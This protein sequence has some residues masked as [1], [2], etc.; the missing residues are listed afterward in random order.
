VGRPGNHYHFVAASPK[1]ATSLRRMIGALHTL[2]ARDVNLLDGAPDRPIWFQFWDTC[3]T[4]PAS[5]FARL[6]YVM[7]NPVKHGLVTAA[8]DYEFC[9]AREFKARAT[10]AFARRVLSYRCDR[11]TVADDF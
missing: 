8:E 1:D 10:P 7:D 11:V 5:Y 6:H 9:S 3:L 2:T 4:Y